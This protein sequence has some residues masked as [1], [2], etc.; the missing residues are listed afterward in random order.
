M[1][2]ALSCLVPETENVSQMGSGVETKLLAQVIERFLFISLATLHADLFHF[3][4][5]CVIFI[6]IYLSKATLRNQLCRGR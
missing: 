2:T 4:S 6:Y 5:F 1:R 3:V